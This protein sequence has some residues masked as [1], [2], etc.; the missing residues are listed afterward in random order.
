M[1]GTRAP[2]VAAGAQTGVLARCP[3]GCG[4]VPC[5]DSGPASTVGSGASAASD[6]VTNALAQP[7]APLP[8]VVL[9]R[10][11]A[12]YGADF[13]SVRVHDGSTAQRAARSVG[14]R[15]FTIGNRIVF[16]AGEYQPDSETGQQLI[17]HE[18][19]HVV[20][21][22]FAAPRASAGVP[23]GTSPAGPISRMPLGIYRAVETACLAPS[24]VP[25]VTDNQASAL[26]RIV[27]IPIIR[28]YCAEVGCAPFATDY[29][30]VLDNAGLYIGFL[31]AHNP[32]LTA[33]DIV[34]LALAAT[35]LGGVFRPDIL[36]HK[37]PRLEYEEIKPDSAVG[38]AAGRVKQ[39]GLAVLFARFSLPYVPGIT[40]SGTGTLPLVTLPGPVE[41][42][43]EWHRNGPGLVVYNFCVRG[44]KSILTAYGI[45]AII[46]AVILIILS[47]GEILPPLPVPALAAGG[48]LG[49]A[50]AVAAAGEASAGQSAAESA[51]APGAATTDA[52]TGQSP[53]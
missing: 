46:I 27:E 16:G 35:V 23:D 4:S 19:A 20:Q 48:L 47:R 2:G 33:L 18:L 37:P 1:A 45:A 12:G 14:A 39:A 43:L 3:G 17:A 32:H 34:E 25:S 44:E 9:Q 41:V 53:A 52:A 30:D 36:T 8:P 38:R 28:N 51:V 11:Q 21:Q 26:G 6:G 42:F 10:M 49:L 7:G 13:S 29:F 31:G 24:E 40:W 22:G 50:G 15:A 5:H